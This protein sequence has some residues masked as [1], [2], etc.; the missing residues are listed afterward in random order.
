MVFGAFVGL[1]RVCHRVSNDNTNFGS[2]QFVP[3]K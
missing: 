2:P 3:Q 1:E